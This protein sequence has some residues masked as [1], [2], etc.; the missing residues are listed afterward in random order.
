MKLEIAS[1]I[2]I[3]ILIILSFNCNAGSDKYAASCAESMSAGQPAKALAA[4]EAA[5]KQ[6]ATAHEAWLCKGRALGAQGLYAEAQKAMEQGIKT[7]KSDYDTGIA[8]LLLGNLHKQNQA[9]TLASQHYQKS[10]SLFEQQ[11]NPRFVYICHVLLGETRALAKDMNAALASYTAA[12][13]TANN[14]NERADSYAYIAQTHAALGQ[15]DRAIEHQLKSV[16]MQKRVGTPDQY[17]SATLQLGQY[18]TQAKDYKSAENTYIKLR[19]FA[20]ANGGLYY[21]A[22]ASLVMAQ[23]ALAS[24]DANA[25]KAYLVS[26]ES[27][28][29]TNNDKELNAEIAAFA[30]TM[31]K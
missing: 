4:A 25:A 28:A 6:D 9:Y 12:S 3:I 27:I 22:K 31:Q 2:Q 24:G 7:T 8:N 10:L 20:K 21:E 26:A 23:N 11:Q 30:Q 29:N 15:H 16:M 19:D 14:D 18:Q 13:K 17:A 5:L 1:K